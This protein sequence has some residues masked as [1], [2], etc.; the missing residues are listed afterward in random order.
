MGSR[1]G[2]CPRKEHIRE[3]RINQSPF[4]APYDTL[5]FGRTEVFTNPGT[6]NP[7]A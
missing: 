5:S 7:T 3:I 1:A 2:A 6:K 4:S